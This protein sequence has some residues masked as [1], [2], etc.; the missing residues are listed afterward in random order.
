MMLKGPAMR[1]TGGKRL[2]AAGTAGEKALRWMRRVG[3]KPECKLAGRERE[4]V[5]GD[6]AGGQ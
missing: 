3:N 2:W 6:E 4:N 5:V 1:T